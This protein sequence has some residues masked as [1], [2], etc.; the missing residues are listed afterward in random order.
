MAVF[1]P[2]PM[3]RTIVVASRGYQKTVIDALH[4]MNAAHFVDYVERREGEMSSFRI[5]RPL[6]DGASVSEKLVRLRAL[7]RHLGLEGTGAART[8]SVAEIEDKLAQAIFTVE[9]DILSAAESKDRVQDA[10]DTLAEEESRL[11]PLAPLP[12]AL[13]DYSGYEAVT[14][15]VGFADEATPAELRR[16]VPDAIVLAGEEG[17]VAVFV[18][19]ASADA[20]R[21]VLFRHGYR[22]HVPPS[23]SGAVSDRL[24]T[25]AGS[26]AELE[27]KLASATTALESLRA[28]HGDFL[29]AAE[30]HLSIQAAKA[31]APLSFATS[32]N[33]FAIDC[34]I[35]ESMVRRVRVELEKATDNNVHVEFLPHVPKPMHGVDDIHGGHDTEHDPHAE[36]GE[37]PTMLANPGPAKPFQFFTEMFS[38]PKYDEIDPTLILSIAFP[39][40]FGF[41]IGDLGLGLVMAGLGYLMFKKLAHV[42]GLKELGFAILLA[43]AIAAVF[44]G[45]VFKDAFGIPL[46]TTDHM[47]DELIEQ[48]GPGFTCH[49]L[50]THLG[51]PTWGCMLAQDPH[52]LAEPMIGKITDV[53]TMLLLSVLVAFVHLALGLL[54][55]IRNESGHGAKHVVAK[56]SWF[57]LLL[58]F[59]PAVVALLRPDMFADHAGDALRVHPAITMHLPLATTTAYAIAGVGVLAGGV[60][61]G[62]AEGVVGVLEI[63]SMLSNILSY[64]RLGA[65]AIAKGAMAVAFNKLTLVSL[66]L[67]G[68][69]PL[70]IVGGLLAFVFVQALLFVLGVLSSGIQA[71][72]LNYVEFFTKFYKGGGEKFRPFGHARRYSTAGP[73]A[74]VGGGKL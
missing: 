26:R 31:E 13:E 65:V 64:L 48:V 39:L 63:P 38:V 69:N 20:A 42:E 43:G 67:L 59:F 10:I 11:R 6:A 32:E 16:A 9:Q 12:L 73:P 4:A 57:L 1:R 19:T 66:T 37:P 45:L 17:L 7:V 15:F 21:D 34:W 29:V 56:L 25:I 53:P 22:E 28:K 40:F 47:R 68:G 58:T 61:L 49:D 8:F 55:G 71:I 3:Q 23:G 41:M 62:W 18:P 36:R 24:A 27:A 14:P 70:V 2:E 44:G 52:F 60:L 74:S 33:A 5:G 30:E 72:R 46:G 35:P 51:E 54:F 50:Y